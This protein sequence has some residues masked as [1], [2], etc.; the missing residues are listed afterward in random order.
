MRL[1]ASLPP[2]PGGEE[3]RA[4]LLLNGIVSGREVPRHVGLRGQRGVDFGDVQMGGHAAMSYADE[5]DI[6]P[7]GEERC[8][9]MDRSYPYGKVC[10]TRLG[11]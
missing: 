8:T 4:R 10:R 7:A 1:H 2:L 11:K 9:A 3:A 6:C 5:R